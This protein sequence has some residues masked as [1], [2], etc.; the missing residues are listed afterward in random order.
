MRETNLIDIRRERSSFEMKNSVREFRTLVAREWS[1]FLLVAIGTVLFSAAVNVFLT[2]LGLYNGGALGLAQLIRT[3]MTDYLKLPIPVGVDIAGPIFFVLNI[4]LFLLAYKGVSRLF[5][6]KTVL[7][8]VLTTLV[9]GV[10][11]V[12]DP[13]VVEDRLTACVIGGLMYGAGVGMCLYAGGSGGGIDILAIYFSKRYRGFSCGKVTA[14]INC[15]IYAV[16]AILYSLETAIYCIIYAA[17]ASFTVDR[18][19]SQNIM[20]Q[21]T[22]FTKQ[23]GVADAIMKNV[24][25]G[26]TEWKGDGAYTKEDT[27]ILVTAISKYEMNLLRRT[28]MEI[29]PNAFIIYNKVM[30]IDGNYLKKF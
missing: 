25:R 10:I 2:P 23:P 16:C 5:F 9:V 19:H 1:K 17:I 8:V 18:V 28:V 3:L 20:V 24:Y 7:S 11:P 13:L 27:N 29:D 12:P 4:P 15:F 21:V 26:V 30:N 14:I 22:V 6:M